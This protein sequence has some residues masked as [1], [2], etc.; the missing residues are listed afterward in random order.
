MRS[1]L[2]AKT[3]PLLYQVFGDKTATKI[4]DLHTGSQFFAVR[5]LG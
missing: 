3:R 4:R 1:T 2:I 5:R